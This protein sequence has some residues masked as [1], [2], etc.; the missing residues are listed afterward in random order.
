M[1]L[2]ASRLTQEAFKVLSI[3]KYMQL[4]KVQRVNTQKGQCGSLFPLL[5]LHPD[6]RGAMTAAHLSFTAL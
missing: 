2:P 4:P 3:E 6:G 5:M 1:H